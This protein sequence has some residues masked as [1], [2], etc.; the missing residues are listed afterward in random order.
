MTEQLTDL[1][2]AP[3]AEASEREHRDA[4]AALQRLERAATA[5]WQAVALGERELDQVA[6]ERAN[7][8]DDPEQIERA[9]TLFR[10]YDERE[11]QRLLAALQALPGPAAN[12]SGRR[13]GVIGLS[14]AAI[15]AAIAIGWF[16]LAGPSEST[17]ASPRVAAAVPQYSIETDGGLAKTRGTAQ[18]DPSKPLRYAGA[19]EFEWILRPR[20]DLVGPT[21]TLTVIARDRR[22]HATS[23]AL[24]PEFAPSGSIRLSGSIAKIGLTPGEWTI[25]F[26]LRWLSG[27]HVDSIVLALPLTLEP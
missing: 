14:L 20:S 27:G 8:G 26:T 1:D 23:L 12:D 18:P 4:V 17:D 9:K 16:A 13:R 10:P 6:V 11:Q 2:S 22:G 15:A 7:A 5:D 21:P 19:N 24:V 3:P 25:E